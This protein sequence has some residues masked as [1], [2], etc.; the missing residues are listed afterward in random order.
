MGR[1]LCCQKESCQMQCV[2]EQVALRHMTK[3]GLF[4]HP[5]GLFSVLR[6]GETKIVT[7]SVPKKEKKRPN[8][9]L[10]PV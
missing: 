3:G 8:L 6:P 10:T 9:S 2:L 7:K 5:E 4:L 1:R